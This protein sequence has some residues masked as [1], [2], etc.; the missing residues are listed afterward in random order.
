MKKL[1]ENF[2]GDYRVLRVIFS[3]SD[4]LRTLEE[5]HTT[6]SYKRFMQYLEMLDVKATIDEDTRA[7]ELKKAA[8]A[9]QTK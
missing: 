2:S 8:V 5:L 1:V 4:P 7:K 6:I 9:A 3:T